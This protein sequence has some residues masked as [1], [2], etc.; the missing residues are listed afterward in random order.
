MLTRTLN[1]EVLHYLQVL[2]FA[3]ISSEGLFKVTG[4]QEV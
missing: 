2:V 3:P 1:I 4:F